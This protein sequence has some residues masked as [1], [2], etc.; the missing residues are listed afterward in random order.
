M[1]SCKNCGAEIK[2]SAA[3]CPECGLT[4]G[5]Q[6]ITDLTGAHTKDGR[7]K[8]FS[9]IEGKKPMDHAERDIGSSG[10]GQTITDLPKVNLREAH[11]KLKEEIKEAREKD[12][13]EQRKRN[14]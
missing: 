10:G 14:Q 3:D 11:K 9:E 5:G 1:D 13:E 7:S 12:R 6:T 8:L 2:H 4:G